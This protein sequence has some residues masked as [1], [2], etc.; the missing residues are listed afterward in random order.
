MNNYQGNNQQ[1]QVKEVVN[2]WREWFPK[3]FVSSE[4]LIG[5]N[6]NYRTATV[7]ISE[8]RIKEVQ[9]SQAQGGGK[10]DKPVVYFRGKSKG[11]ILNAS[12][13]TALE[14]ICGS[15]NPRNW[16]GKTVELFV[17]K[18]VKCPKSDTHPSG[19]A[20]V[21]R[22]RKAAGAAMQ[23]QSAQA[24][25]SEPVQTSEIK[26]TLRNR[27]ANDVGSGQPDSAAEHFSEPATGGSVSDEDIPF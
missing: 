3:E 6:G 11:I 17:E 5:E 14:Q 23:Q 21:V 9:Q 19:R 26:E 20:D 12:I 4:D 25:S 2:S 7:A 8:V 22:I 18:N 15:A 16:V 10:K 13:G 27:E 1:S 24:A